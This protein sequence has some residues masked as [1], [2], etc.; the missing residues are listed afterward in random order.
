[1]KRHLLPLALFMAVVTFLLFALNPLGPEDGGFQNVSFPNSNE[2]TVD[3]SP[4]YLGWAS[5]A[6]TAIIAAA[7]FWFKLQDKR[8]ADRAEARDVHDRSNRRDD[9][10]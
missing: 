9:V 1:M 8:R 4:N 5:F 3:S 2:T 7:G 6:L 10:R